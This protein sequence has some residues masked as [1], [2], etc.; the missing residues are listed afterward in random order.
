L[1]VHL[2]LQDLGMAGG[3]D[4]PGDPAEDAGCGSQKEEL[5]S[6]RSSRSSIPSVSIHVDEVLKILKEFL[7]DFVKLRED[8][9]EDESLH[10]RDNS[11]DAEYWEALPHVIPEPTL[12]LWDALAEALL[13]YHRVLSRRARLLSEASRL[14]QQNA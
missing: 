4:A 14:Q 5:Q 8:Y 9:F 2:C 12:K 11:R 7:K 6:C 3:E 10:V 13:E 1:R